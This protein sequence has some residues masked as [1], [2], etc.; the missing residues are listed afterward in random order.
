MGRYAWIMGTAAFATL[1]FVPGVVR[2]WGLECLVLLTTGFRC[3]GCGGTH[4]LSHFFAGRIG[5]A[6]EH[7]ALVTTVVMALGVWCVATAGR[8]VWTRVNSADGIIEEEEY[9]GD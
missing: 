3:P 1:A 5:S 4:A 6:F 8:D 9:V 2:A 7:N